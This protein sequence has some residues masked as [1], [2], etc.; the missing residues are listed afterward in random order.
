MKKFLCPL[1]LCVLCATVLTADDDQKVTKDRRF[2][3]H[4]AAERF[5]R[6]RSSKTHDQRV[7]MPPVYAVS[8]DKADD[9]DITPQQRA[10]FDAARK[11]RFEIMVLIGA[12]KIMPEN[13]R[14]GLRAE[15]LKRI[16][17]DF[18]S[19]IVQ[20]K[21]RIAKAEADLKKLRDELAEREAQGDKLVEKELDRLLKMPMPDRRLNR[22]KK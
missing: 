5:N 13:Q 14:A 1:V 11:R 9:D 2:W 16:E 3:Q 15:L 17:E 22:Q 21:A 12:Y 18:Q 6:D 4:N 10:R 7:V 19:V 8:K 20:Q